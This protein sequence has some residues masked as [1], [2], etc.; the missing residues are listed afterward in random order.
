MDF[1]RGDGAIADGVVSGCVEL[2][3]TLVLAAIDVVVIV[4]VAKILV[5]DVLD[6]EVSSAGVGCSPCG[7]GVG[8]G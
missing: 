8:V 4:V 7:E 5:V 1:A 2:P 6:V 3:T